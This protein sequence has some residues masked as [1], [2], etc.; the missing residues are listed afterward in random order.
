MSLH[1]MKKVLFGVPSVLKKCKHNERKRTLTEM[2]LSLLFLTPHK[3]YKLRSFV[4]VRKRDG[5]KVKV[6][7][8]VPSG[9]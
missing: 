7:V 5:L 9:N 3:R 8:H 4:R 6:S 2:S 1:P